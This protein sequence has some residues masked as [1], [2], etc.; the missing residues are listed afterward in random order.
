M[1]YHIWS[2]IEFYEVRISIFSGEETKTWKAEEY[3]RG[4]VANKCRS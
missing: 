2:F 1:F 3:T 4:H